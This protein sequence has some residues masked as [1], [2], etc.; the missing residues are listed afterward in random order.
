MNVVNY[1]RDPDEIY[2]R[3]FATIEAEADLA[4]FSPA[5]R[6][7]VVRMAHACGMTDIAEAIRFSVGAAEAGR[8]ALDGGAPIF[9]D[10][11]MVR[12][13]ILRAACRPAMT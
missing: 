1:V 12:A 4:R 7:I 10:V 5:M 2:R 11:E 9:C 6:A 8:A 3:S 13:G